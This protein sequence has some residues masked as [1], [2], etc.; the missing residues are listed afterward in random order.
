VWEATNR[1]AA[2]VM[3]AA[4]QGQSIEEAVRAEME[5]TYNWFTTVKIP[6]DV[7]R[8]E[9]YKVLGVSGVGANGVEGVKEKP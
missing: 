1:I 6:A 7:V 3:I 2:P 5:R 9:L 4:K 8:P